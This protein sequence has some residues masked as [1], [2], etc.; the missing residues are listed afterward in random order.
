M[1]DRD[2]AAMAAVAAARVPGGLVYQQ[3][4]FED[5]MEL[6]LAAADVA[7]QRAGASTVSEL[8]AVGVPAVLVPLPGRPAT[9][10]RSTPAAWPRPARRWSYPTPSSTPAG[11]PSEL[12]RLLGDDQAAPGHGRRGPG[13]WRGPGRRP[14]WPPWPRS[15]PVR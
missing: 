1:G 9:T 11:W 10:R 5:R 2:F 13:A 15:T 14:R 4:R 6:L 7:V 8:T 12:D 3:V